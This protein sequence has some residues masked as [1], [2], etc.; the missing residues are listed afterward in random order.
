[1]LKR[2]RQE[3]A[4][5]KHVRRAADRAQRMTTPEVND[6]IQTTLAGLA[7]YSEAFVRDG[8]KFPQTHDAEV[9]TE[10]VRELE[11]RAT[12]KEYRNEER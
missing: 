9:L 4:R 8:G 6:W 3:D 10:L 1:M 2:K 11:N 5:P 12:T 7:E